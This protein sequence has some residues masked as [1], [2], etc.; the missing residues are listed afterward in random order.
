MSV[1]GWSLLLGLSAAAANVVGGVV[2]THREWD[3]RWLSFF[4]ALGS[5]FMLATAVA[6]MLPESLALAPATAPFAVVAGYALVHL[7]EHAL[8]PH[9]HFGEETHHEEF[10][11][12]AKALRVLLA[13]VVHTFFD[14]IAIGSGFQVSAKL[15][16][17][18]FSAVILH[19]LPEGLT[20]AS[21]MLAGGSSRM[22][23][24]GSAVLLGAA[25]VAGVLVMGFS[26]GLLK[27]GL[28][29][30][31]GV[32]LYVAA[33]DLI[34]EANKEKGFGMAWIVLLGMALMLG[35]KTLL[36]D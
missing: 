29:L 36:P 25:T 5:G 15:G 20:V 35:M 7:L 4:V 8:V 33:T 10:L 30:S 23:A 28:P 21:V 6:E 19:K 2:M 16:W 22:R 31:A 18:I 32:T 1:L 14:G 27:Y 13:L 11:H 24:L 34:P 9:F 26:R 12:S 3:R 17:L